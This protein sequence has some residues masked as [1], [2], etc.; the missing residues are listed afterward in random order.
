MPSS[1]KPVA[2]LGAGSWGT[3]LA[4]TAAR[5]HQDNHVFLWDHDP[6][7]CEKIQTSRENNRYLPGIS[8]PENLIAIADLERIIE[9]AAEIII[10]VPSHAF[11]SIL[12]TLKS[13]G[14][15][16]A[17]LTW[18]TKGLEPQ[19]GLLMHQV[20][21]D[22]LDDN[23]PIAVLSGPTF[24]KEVAQGLPTAITLASSS[25]HHAQKIISSLHS[26]YFR[27]YQS[28]DVIGVEL[29]GSIKNIL[30][31]ATGISDGL[32]FSANTRAALITRGLN[33]M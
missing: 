6:V 21:S 28:Q 26:V 20:V 7:H 15:P 17:G 29:G 24:A 9:T 1:R 33:E 3:A 8:L 5:T 12:Q 30:A 32:G 10:A 11:R 14:H 23:M 25:E 31:I 16:L 22:E 19:T 4:I 18:A 2:I 27:V 13:T